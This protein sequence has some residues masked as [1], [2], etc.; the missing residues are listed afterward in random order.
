MT[1]TQL[2]YL[3]AI[4]DAGLNITLAAERVHAT[5]PG[6]SKQ[7]KQLEGELGFQLFARKGK[8][9]HE[10]TPAGREVIQRAR[11]ILAEARNVHA[12]AA[13]IRGDEEGELTIATTH[14][15]ARFVLPTAI[16]AVKNRYPAIVV[17]LQPQGDAQVMGLFEHGQA[18][19]AIISTPGTPP[20][21]G[22]AVPLFRWRRSVVVQR[23][24]ALAKL[25]R[26]LQFADLDGEQ[27]VSYESSLRPESSLQRAFAAANIVPRFTFTS[28]DADLI[29]TYVRAGLGVGV[30]AEMAVLADDARDLVVLDADALFPECTTWLVLRRD[31]VL[32]TY[33]AALA[34]FIAPQLDPRD[35]QRAVVGE[36]PESW[37]DPPSWRE[38]RGKR[39]IE[40]SVA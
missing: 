11:I 34:G 4:Y 3:V 40:G 33:A 7:L 14:T 15:Q 25:D 38:L 28:R 26:P 32:R 5:Q 16:A 24:H 20:S 35:L 36:L 39:E 13:N 29:K 10:I 17:H 19:L 18:D 37:P 9:L 6:L 12:I 27:L 30:F 21:E 23:G 8:S 2:R 31:R 1:L 22:L